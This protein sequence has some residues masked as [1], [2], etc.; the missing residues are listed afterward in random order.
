MSH[1]HQNPDYDV[2]A[3]EYGDDGNHGDSNEYDEYE[4][5]S[6]Y[7]ESDHNDQ[8]FSPSEPD[9]HNT[10]NGDNASCESN[11]TSAEREVNGN[12][13]ESEWL[14]HEGGEPNGVDDE[15]E[16]LEYERG[17][18]DRGEHED[19]EREN[20]VHEPQEHEQD[21]TPELEELE[22]MSYERGHEPERFER[23]GDQTYE[24]QRLEQGNYGVHEPEYE[25]DHE[26]EPRETD[27]G[28]HAPP[29][30]FAGEH[31]DDAHG[32]AHTSEH[33]VEPH[34]Y[35][36]TNTNPTLPA[37]LSYT[38]HY[39]P[40]RPRHDSDE[41]LELREL[42]SMYAKWG[43]EPLELAVVHSAYGGTADSTTTTPAPL[44]PPHS[45]THALH[46]TQPAEPDADEQLELEELE[47]MYAKWGHEPPD[48]TALHSAHG[49]TSDSTSTTPSLQCL[50][51]YDDDEV[52]EFRNQGAYEL[53]EL[54]YKEPHEHERDR[55]YDCSEPR[56]GGHGVYEPH[57]LEPFPPRGRLPRARSPPIEPSELGDHV[58]TQDRTPSPSPIRSYTPN[59][60]PTHSY[61]D[62]LRCDYNNGIPSAIAYIQELQYFTEDCMDE[63]E[64]WKADQRAEIRKNYNIAY[65]KRDYLATPRSWSAIGNKGGYPRTIP[66]SRPL[67]PG[68]KR[69][70]YRNSRATHSRATYYRTLQP[71]PPPEPEENDVA[72]APPHTLP[73]STTWNRGRHGNNST[74]KSPHHTNSGTTPNSISR[75][76]PPPWPN[77]HRDQDRNQH[78]HNGEYT[79]ARYT[80]GQRPPPRPNIP[81][82][83]SLILS[84]ANSRPPPWPNTWHCHHNAHSPVAST[85]PARPP[86][87]PIIPRRI[88][89]TPQNR[90]NAK[91]RAKAKSRII[92]DKVSI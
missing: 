19:A 44:P 59:E 62:T 33:V 24:P 86:P 35:R 56:D 64:E 31:D 43:H 1:Y 88:H 79:P 77:K 48:P 78:Q 52:F 2:Y 61:L 12:G 36:P 54:E 91:Q 9:Y 74:S 45:P 14:D 17:E 66:S 34:G 23:R 85:P 67:R 49:G 58:E 28:I 63:H 7:A 83:P 37:P 60:N 90:R 51:T 11:E 55:A 57:Q 65:P 75:S 30:A 80:M 69:R 72:P 50:P 70:R 13:Y 39:E 53:E 87:W 25:P 81:T 15:Q 4:S 40:Q 32:L 10:G 89:S 84:I 16:R 76:R 92:S 27:N 47:R 71:R 42:E 68:L 18:L 8:D 38:P 46:H 29:T 41:A 6:S 20:E 26:R 3:Y 5:Y 82:I 21:D 22:H 73:S